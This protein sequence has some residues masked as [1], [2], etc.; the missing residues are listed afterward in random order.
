M[1]KLNETWEQFK[2]LGM[3]PQITNLVHR[4]HVDDAVS[5]RRHS[6]Y[7]IQNLFHVQLLALSIIKPV[8]YGGTFHTQL[9]QHS[10]SGSYREG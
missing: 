6:Q 7:L 8:H 10:T 3:F 1:T 4:A 9:F 2:R 5:L